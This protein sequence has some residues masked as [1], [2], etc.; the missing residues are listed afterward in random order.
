ME[1]EQKIKSRQASVGVIGLGYV[2]LPV[3]Q[4]FTSQG[5]PVIGFDV[6]AEKV[7]MLSA[8]KTY[9][10]HI[11]DEVIVEMLKSAFEPTCDYGR[12]PEADAV[13]ICVPTPLGRHEEPDVSY[14]E[15]AAESIAEHMR[16][17]QLIVLE[18]TTYPGTTR[19]VVLPILNRSGLTVG[20]DF[21]LGYSP[22]RVD[23]GNRE[24]SVASIPKVV[25][26]ITEKC[27]RL[28]QLLYESVVVKTVPVSTVETAEA[29]KLL[30]NIYRAVNIALVNEL[31]TLF[32]RMDIDIFEVIEAARTKPFGFQAFYPG[33]GLGG[34]C[35]PI[36]PFYLSWRA[37][38]F[39][40][41]PKFIH[42]A[43]EINTAMPEFVVRRVAEALNGQRKPLNG[44]SVLLLG[45][46]YKQDVDDTRESPSL[47]VM[48]LLQK[49]GAQVDYSDPY[50]PELRHT[51]AYAFEK[52]SVELTVQNIRKYDC[53][54][55]TT[56][57]SAFDY[58][59]IREHANLIVDTRNAFR[60]KGNRRGKVF[61]A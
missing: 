21:Y 35:V 29:A 61:K 17:G 39:G 14:I 15:G 19:E 47:R 43:G 51:R 9:L 30:E 20:E 10:R 5:F 16:P 4:A 12:L 28:T 22:E 25:A 56:A 37:R 23:P 52:N 1:L 48:E 26:G 55:V 34:H 45:M 31:K 40:A 50:I 59:L 60:E 44:S 13:L 8:G 58:D 3:A 2:G 27:C 33:P 41:S 24:F 11:G 57:H 49:E 38:E 32:H 42:L 54:I 46:A 18:S 7:E 53:I 6:D 36:D